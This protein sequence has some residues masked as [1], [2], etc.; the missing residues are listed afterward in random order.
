MVGRTVSHY[1]VVAHLGQGGMGAIYAADDV[2]LNRRIALKVLP[3]E[4]AADPSRL[5]RFEQEA[6]AVAALDHPNIVTIHSTRSRRL[7][8]L[9][10]LVEGKTAD[11]IPRMKL[12]SFTVAIP[13]ADRGPPISAHRVAISSSNVMVSREAA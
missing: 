13:L 5:R 2:T 3:A 9:G 8:L 4:R 7:G 11:A 10:G 6:K 1:R 12:S